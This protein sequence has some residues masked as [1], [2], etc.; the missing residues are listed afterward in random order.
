[1]NRPRASAARLLGGL[2]AL[3]LLVATLTN[4]APGAAGAAMAPAPADK[5]PVCGMFVAKYPD[6]LARVAFADG[7]QVFFDGAKDMFRYLLDPGRYQ[8]QRQGQEIV[9]VQVTD[10]YELSA[11]DGRRAWYV[12]GSD[13][14]GPMGHELIPFAGEQAAREF[15]RDHAGRRLLRFDEVT[16]ELLRELE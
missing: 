9:A 14:L 10:Y 8:P 13:I 2:A 5:C 7:G 6:F 3:W 12:V 1:M 4:A 15:M 16:A 11:T